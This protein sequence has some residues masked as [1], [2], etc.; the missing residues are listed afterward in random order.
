MTAID[1]VSAENHL[2]IDSHD[3]AFAE[4]NV[5]LRFVVEQDVSDSEVFLM[6]MIEF[7]AATDTDGTKA[8]EVDIGETILSENEE[9]STKGL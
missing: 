8:F 2:S 4:Q 6:V 3:L 1:F 9:G 7:V 5:I